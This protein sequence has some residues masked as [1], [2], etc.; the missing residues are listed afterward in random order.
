MHTK[1]TFLCEKKMVRSHIEMR[2]AVTLF[3][4]ILTESSQLTEYI[5]KMPPSLR[6]FPWFA[7]GNTERRA[8]IGIKTPKVTVGIF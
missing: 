2:Q 6:P 4:N 8:V 7:V 3:Q 5:V 1:V